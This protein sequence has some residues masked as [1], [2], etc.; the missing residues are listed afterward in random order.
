ML[1]NIYLLCNQIFKSQENCY[2]WWNGSMS[3]VHSSS[4]QI[5]DQWAYY[6]FRGA[7][8]AIYMRKERTNRDGENGHTYSSDALHEHQL[9]G[10]IHSWTYKSIS[11][12]NLAGRLMKRSS[13]PC[14]STAHQNR[15]PR[16][17]ELLPLRPSST[18]HH[19]FHMQHLPKSSLA[20]ARAVPRDCITLY[21]YKKID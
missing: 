5:L 11:M 7:N 3:I 17:R 21:Y 16:G 14:P 10:V 4:L 20:A 13:F 12:T 8:S 15:P 2:V 18:P 9:L 6:S 19:F 1:A